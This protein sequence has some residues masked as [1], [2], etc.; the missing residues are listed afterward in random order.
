MQ[1]GHMWASQAAGRPPRRPRLAH[2][3]A[4]LRLYQ[5]NMSRAAAAGGQG[6]AVG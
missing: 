1:S 4:P 2:T 6:F 3:Q 5:P